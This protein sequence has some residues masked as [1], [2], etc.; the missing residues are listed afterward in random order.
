[1][2]NWVG[3]NCTKLKVSHAERSNGVTNYNLKKLFKLALDVIL[4]NSDKPIRIIIK[5]GLFMSL[6]SFVFAAFFLINYLNGE[7]KVVGFTSLII[8]IWFLSG[9][10]LMTLGIVGLYIGKTYEAVKNRPFYIIKNEINLKN[11]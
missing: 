6:I 2:V 8:S 7:I 11:E 3:F 4:V 9:F 10:I 5:F 1:M